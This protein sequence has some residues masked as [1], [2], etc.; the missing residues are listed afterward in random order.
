M[1]KKDLVPRT[2][3]PPTLVRRYG[4]KSSDIDLSSWR[5]LPARLLMAWKVLTNLRY[6]LTIEIALSEKEQQRLAEK[7]AAARANPVPSPSAQSPASHRPQI[8][9]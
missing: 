5:Y 6:Y 4:G 1:T 3:K 9:D 8:D 7:Q 2:A